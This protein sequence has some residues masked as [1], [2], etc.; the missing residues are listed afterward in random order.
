M[1]LKFDRYTP[2]NNRSIALR[3]FNSNETEVNSYYWSFKAISE[4]CGHIGRK[5]EKEDKNRKTKDVFEASGPDAGRI[6][7]TIENWN[8]SRN[9]LENWL[10][11]AAL[12]S[13]SSFLESYMRQIIRAALMSDPLVQ[14][15]K[16]RLIDGVFLLKSNFEFPY[17][18]LIE[19]MT[20]GDWPKRL[21]SIKKV[22]GNY[23]HEMDALI[24]QLEEIRKRR[25]SFAH[26][27][28][29]DIDYK[30]PSDL[31]IRDTEKI[32]QKN[33]IKYMSSVSRFA[34]L[35]DEYLYI[36][37]IGNFEI[38]H[39]Y[40][41]EKLKNNAVSAKYLKGQIRLR[42]NLNPSLKFCGD[43]IEYYNNI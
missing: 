42:L 34:K 13:V 36:K 25:N 32:S 6:P 16:S 30:N 38:I 33:L 4:Y 7:E 9:K 1:P 18:P 40:H 35:F 37:Y 26:A 5:I 11:M 22:F 20:K 41:N 2:F 23:P 43:L 3:A 27:F 17:E 19:S 12:T 10:R 28:G 8:D 39:F 29:R 14:Y 15:G 21:S 24:R 31:D